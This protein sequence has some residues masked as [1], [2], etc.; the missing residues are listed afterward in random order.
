MAAKDEPREIAPAQGTGGKKSDDE[1]V[2]I[3]DGP[4]GS[5][6]GL[7]RRVIGF[8]HE[9]DAKGKQ[10]AAVLQTRPLTGDC[11]SALNIDPLSASK[12]DP[13]LGTTFDGGFLTVSMKKKV[14]T[15]V[16]AVVMWSTR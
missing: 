8:G 14:A 9:A 7:A 2:A 16:G 11:Q 10:V 12:I 13:P 1:T 4:S 3:E 15:V 5:T 6:V